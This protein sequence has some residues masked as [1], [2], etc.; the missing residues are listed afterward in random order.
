MKIS[1]LHNY[2]IYKNEQKYKPSFCAQS[3]DLQRTPR[4]D[5]FVNSKRKEKYAEHS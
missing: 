1:F 3:I 5:V 2:N 4:K